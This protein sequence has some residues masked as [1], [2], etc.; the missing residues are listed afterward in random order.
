MAGERGN[1]LLRLLDR[2]LGIPLVQAAGLLRRRR[3]RPAELQ[4]V[5]VL[6]LG[7]IG[8]LVLLSGPLEDLA[9]SHPGCR[10]TL[11]C[12]GANQ[13]VARLL[14]QASEV[15][16]L[17]V[18][19]PLVSA[20]LIRGS[21]TFDAWI[22]SG[23]WPRIGALLSL[24]ALAGFRVGFSSPGQHRHQIYDAVAAHSRA[25]HELDNFR[26]LLGE[27][28][29]AGESLP[30][31]AL[32]AEAAAELAHLAPAG[33]YA[34]LHLFPGGLRAQMKAWP[35]ERW[36][37]LARGLLERGLSLVLSGGPEDALGNA[38]FAR[39]LEGSLVFNLAGVPLDVTAQALLGA[40]LAVSVNT[41]IMHLAAALDVPLVSLNGPTSLLRWGPVTRAGRGE[42]LSSQRPC[43][44]CLHLGFEYGCREGGCMADIEVADA[45]AAADRLLAAPGASRERA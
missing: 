17:P 45:L 9:R 28:G 2:G 33:P 38:D 12:S 29:V 20:A 1:I 11:F 34:V 15:V 21:G 8:D 30:R 32:P 23:Q 41:G 16:V 27:L 42:A 40:A 6:C 35:L 18:K 39:R 22:D 3:K 14:P 19:R 26:A 43:A 24:A 36:E 31:L 44:P 13:G 4:R 10:V 7:C 37:K 25:R 5:G